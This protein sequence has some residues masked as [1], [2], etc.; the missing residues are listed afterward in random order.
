MAS[1]SSRMTS[2]KPFLKKGEK[3]KKGLAAGLV[4]EKG[5]PGRGVCTYSQPDPPSNTPRKPRFSLRTSIF[6][7]TL[8][9]PAC[10]GTFPST[11]VHFP[12]QERPAN[13]PPKPKARMMKGWGA[14]RS[15]NPPL[16]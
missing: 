9:L 14:L 10:G 4:L 7:T 5:G 15:A 3:K 6:L 11:P 16:T 12:P 1:A 2:L 8:I 13:P